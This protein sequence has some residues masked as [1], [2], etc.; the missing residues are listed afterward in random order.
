M[1]NI[2]LDLSIAGAVDRARRKAG[3]TQQDLATKLHAAQGRVSNFFRGRPVR[4]DF[5]QHLLE[6]LATETQR[7]DL[8]GDEIDRILQTIRHAQGLIRGEVRHGARAA[9]LPT[10]WEPSD[11]F[12]ILMTLTDATRLNL[13]KAFDYRNRAHFKAH[14]DCVA[15]G[16]C[17]RW[18]AYESEQVRTEWENYIKE[19]QELLPKVHRNRIDQLQC[20]ILPAD[21]VRQGESIPFRVTIFGDDVCLCS[22]ERAAHTY[23]HGTLYF[24]LGAGELGGLNNALGA[25]FDLCP[26]I[27]DPNAASNSLIETCHKYHNMVRSAFLQALLVSK[28]GG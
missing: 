9:S 6:V 19:V 7:S 27:S 18:I 10:T 1:P 15:R 23:S 4:D 28:V 13:T 8:R 26:E 22:E 17:Y 14:V 2:A 21:A 12:A 11:Y 5:A 20:H 25:L 24:V 16:V 3:I